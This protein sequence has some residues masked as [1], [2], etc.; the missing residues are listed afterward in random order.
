MKQIQ[1]IRVGRP[2]IT[3][4]I[5]K[6]D[7][8]ANFSTLRA[9]EALS[10]V[11]HGDPQTGDLNG[12]DTPTLLG[13]L[14]D[15]ATGVPRAYKGTITILSCYSGQR[16]GGPTS[17][18]ERVAA[19]LG[20]KLTP[21]AKVRGANGYSFG[22][23][24]VGKTGV[25]SVLS[26]DLGEFYFLNGNRDAMRRKWLAHKP[27][28]TNGVLK[29][30]L[31]GAVRVTKTIGENIKNELDGGKLPGKSVEEVA[32]ELV[33]SFA[34][35]A[36]KIENALKDII[37][38]HIPGATIVERIDHMLTNTNAAKV[39]EWNQAIARQYELFEDHYL[40]SPT[41]AAFTTV[42]VL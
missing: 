36:Q 30:K 14:T 9:T 21:G 25:S 28:H 11:S 19:G 39:L 20:G 4:E 34:D 40:W 22:T 18:T 27:T 10:I 32:L 12:I 37:A 17:L 8:T 5:V 24:E 1:Q 2:N 42:A 6:L 35:E 29:T 23:P 38:T 15:Q 33:T 16:K 3:E 13:W 41:D 26:T 7:G 31:G